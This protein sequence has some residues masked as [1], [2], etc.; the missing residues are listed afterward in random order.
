MSFSTNAFTYRSVITGTVHESG[1]LAQLNTLDC[2]SSPVPV[3]LLVN[4]CLFAMNPS[5]RKRC[6]RR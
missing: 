6:S 1:N 5:E 4:P 2:S 3:T